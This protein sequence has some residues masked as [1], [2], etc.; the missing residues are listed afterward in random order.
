MPVP[1]DAGGSGE[2]GV[3]GVVVE[4]EGELREGVVRLMWGGRKSGKI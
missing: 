4:V 1:D 3:G 2:A